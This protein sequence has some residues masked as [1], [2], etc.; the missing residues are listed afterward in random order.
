MNQ[1]SMREKVML[2]VGGL[3]IIA[4]IFYF[5]V[6]W[7]QEQI[8]GGEQARLNEEE[9]EKVRSVL[10]F[11]TTA[12]QMESPLRE[13]AGLQGERVIDEELLNKIREEA[14]LAPDPEHPARINLNKAV[15]KDLYALGLDKEQAQLVRE[16]RS[17]LGGFASIDQ[18]GEIKHSLFYE[19]DEQAVILAKLASVAKEAGIE[20]KNVMQIEPRLAR[21]AK[22][23][24]IPASARA[25][26]I[27]QLYLHELSQEAEGIQQA[28]NA[29]EQQPKQVSNAK[30]W[31][32]PLPDEIPL[33]WQLKLIELIQKRQGDLG[34]RVSEKEGENVD[35]AVAYA[36]TALN[37]T[38]EL[39]EVDVLDKGRRG[40]FGLGKKPVR[41]LTFHQD[42][43]TG[44]VALFQQMESEEAEEEIDRAALEDALASYVKQCAETHHELNDLLK[45]VSMSHKP[46]SYIVEMAFKGDLDKVV[47]L[48]EK[49]ETDHRWIRVRGLKIAIA[50]EKNTLLQANLTMIAVVI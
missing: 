29:G 23:V 45:K 1:L 27:T 13:K 9:L 40:L 25:S 17:Q 37:T 46:R 43:D 8:G 44:L 49:V 31:F 11:R 36:L 7:L 20:P 32:D 42:P 3:G 48:I 5:G 10:A 35:E 38:R 19:Q 28:I 34:V 24:Q 4:A 14:N 33:P 47:R 22:A 26:C 21:S 16:Y 50:D 15:L 18:L 30:R 41:L 6:P 2:I 12:Q 39:V